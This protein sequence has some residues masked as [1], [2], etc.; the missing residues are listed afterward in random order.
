MI[1]LSLLE[2]FDPWMGLIC[3]SQTVVD[4]KSFAKPAEAGSAPDSWLLQVL[5]RS[6]CYTSYRGLYQ[7]L[8]T[9]I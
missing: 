7:S 1:A 2:L 8:E 9:K 3:M 6:M 4:P 5:R